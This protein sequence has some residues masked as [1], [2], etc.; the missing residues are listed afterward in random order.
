MYPDDRLPVKTS[1]EKRADDSDAGIADC[2][3]TPANETISQVAPK[4]DLST[5][6]TEKDIILP[7]RDSVAVPFTSQLPERN[8][9]K[10]ADLHFPEQDEVVKI[11]LNLDPCNDQAKPLS[12]KQTS[13]K[14]SD[15]SSKHERGSTGKVK[16]KSKAV[17]KL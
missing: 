4:S 9:L 16:T 17:N 2:E 13:I 8:E 7:K 14:V 15:V 6:A 1:T 5:N 12:S 3:E 10:S 11:T